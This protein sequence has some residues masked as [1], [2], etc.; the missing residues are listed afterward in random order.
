MDTEKK[1]MRR[2]GRE[3][4]EEQNVEKKGKQENYRKVDKRR[5]TVGIKV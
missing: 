2:T 5:I 3:L 4:I 1:N